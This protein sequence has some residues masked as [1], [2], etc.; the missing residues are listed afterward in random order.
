MTAELA[1]VSKACE[2]ELLSLEALLT[3]AAAFAASK[4]PDTMYLH[5]AMKVPDKDQF[6][7][8]M[9]EEMGTQLKGEISHSS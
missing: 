8:A 9:E 1:H 3:D 6:I 5:Q 4:D 2:G 7:A